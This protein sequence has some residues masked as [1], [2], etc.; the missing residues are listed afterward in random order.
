MQM[1]D[2]MQ[3]PILAETITAVT[4]ILGPELDEIAI[5]RAVIGPAAAKAA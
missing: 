4:D 2:M 1:G 5:E 3:S